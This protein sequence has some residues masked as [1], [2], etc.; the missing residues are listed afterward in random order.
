MCG[1]AYIYEQAFPDEWQFPQD[2]TAQIFSADDEGKTLYT[3]K[4]N[5]WL[6]HQATKAMTRLTLWS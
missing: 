2:R 3:E 1:L 6:G 4:I 5:N